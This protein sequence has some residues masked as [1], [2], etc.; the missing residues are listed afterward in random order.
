M[1]QI[2]VGPMTALYAGCLRAQKT[3]SSPYQMNS[4]NDE[5][6][7]LDNSKIFFLFQLGWWSM[8]TFVIMTC[9]WCLLVKAASG[10]GVIGRK[11]NFRCAGLEMAYFCISSLKE[12][13]LC[14]TLSIFCQ[15][16]SHYS[17]VLLTRKES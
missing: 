7:R 9:N 15:K 14:F 11:Y 17:R 6:I 1:K 10:V 8:F 13:S 4:S 2:C 16:E 3:T 12:L 5:W